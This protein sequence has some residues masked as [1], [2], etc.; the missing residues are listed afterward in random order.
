MA[1]KSKSLIEFKSINTTLHL[2]MFPQRPIPN[3]YAC[4]KCKQELLDVN[5]NETLT[6]N[7]PKKKVSCSNKKC[8]FT[9]YINYYIIDL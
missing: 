9:D 2:G 5:P 7:P 3:G 8:N 6:T 1:K 4:P